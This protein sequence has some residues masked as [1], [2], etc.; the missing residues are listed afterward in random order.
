MVGLVRARKGYGPGPASFLLRSRKDC[1][2]L[3]K[4]ADDDDPE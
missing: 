1:E 3:L 4:L 2:K